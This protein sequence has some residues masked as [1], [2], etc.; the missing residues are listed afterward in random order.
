MSQPDQKHRALL[1]SLLFSAKT[2]IV[3]VSAFP[4]KLVSQELNLI[5]IDR[6]HYWTGQWAPFTWCFCWI[7][8]TSTRSNPDVSPCSIYFSA[9]TADFIPISVSSPPWRVSPRCAWGMSPLGRCSRLQHV[10]LFFQL[11]CHPVGFHSPR[12]TVRKGWRLLQLLGAR[13]LRPQVLAW[14]VS[15][16]G[17]FSSLNHQKSPF[18]V[19]SLTC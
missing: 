13:V 12:I 15:T 11:S 5:S 17:D 7:F 14:L 2:H 18:M 3:P 4:K 8:L 19:Y 6:K 9:P 1:F 10:F 16:M